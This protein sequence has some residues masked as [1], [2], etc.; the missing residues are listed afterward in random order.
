M[1]G[2]GAIRMRWAKFGEL[3]LR[4]YEYLWAALPIGLIV[5]GGAIGGIC[6]GAAMVLNVKLMQGRRTAALKY[7][8]TGLVSLGAVGSYFVLAKVFLSVTGLGGW[9]TAEQVD[10][11]LKSQP[12]FVAIQKGDPDSYARIRTAMIDGL[13]QGKP[14]AEIVAAVNGQL[15]PLLLKYL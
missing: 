14:Q 13:G 9:M 15:E 3:N 11:D 6:G 8:F 5:V 1:R 2:A 4:W 7:A 12:M 10:R